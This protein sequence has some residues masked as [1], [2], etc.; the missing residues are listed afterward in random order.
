MA[1]AEAGIRFVEIALTTPG[2]LDAI[3]QVAARV[4]DG[5]AIGA[6]TVLTRQDVA[7]VAAAGAQ[8]IVTPAVADSIDAAAARGIPVLAGAFTATEALAARSRG[9]TSSSSSPPR[10]VARATSRRCATRC[11]DIPF[12]AVGGVGLDD[13]AAYLGVGAIGVGVGEP[14][15]GGCRVRRE[16]R[17]A[18]G[19]GPRLRRRRRRGSRRDRT[20]SRGVDV[21]TVGE[22]MVSFR[23]SGPLAGGALTMH[24]AGAEAT[25]PIGLSRLGHA[26]AWVGRVGGDPFGELVLRELRAEGMDV[27]TRCATTPAR[28]G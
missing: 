6:G 1:L 22:S 23:S 26:A 7:D 15:R 28:R 20:R 9:A 25:W 12:V 3:E 4:P 14:A 8:F 18:A 17:G 16:P 19:A 11:P 13:V 21:L 24:L 2:A 27:S 10:P 5:V